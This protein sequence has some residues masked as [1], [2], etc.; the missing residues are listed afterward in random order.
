MLAAYS[1]GVI[2]PASAA[3]V[4]QVQLIISGMIR[5]NTC[6]LDSDKLIFILPD[7]SVRELSGKKGKRSSVL[8]IPVTLSECGVNAA[9]VVVTASGMADA[10]VASLWANQAQSGSGGSSGVGL[11]LLQS[12]GSASFSPRGSRSETLPLQP[13]QKNILIFHA[14]ME[15][16]RNKVKAGAFVTTVDL[17]IDYK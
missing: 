10:D 11:R 9:S 3:D 14:A 2:P 17:E 12:N 1:F 8:D 15:T 4:D 7:T 6:T 5:D 13:S 16:T